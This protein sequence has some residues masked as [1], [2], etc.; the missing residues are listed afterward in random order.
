MEKWQKMVF[1]GLASLTLA[2]CGTGGQ[3]PADPGGTDT[4]TTGPALP[5]TDTTTETPGMETPT[6][7]TAD[8]MTMD[9]ILELY[10]MEYPDAQIEEVDFDDDDHN[11]WTYEITGVYENREYEVEY[12][13][14]TGDVLNTEEDDADTDEEYLNFDNI[15]DPTEAISI[16]RQQVNDDATL[17]GWHLDMDDGVPEYEVEFEGT[18]DRDVTIHAETGDVIEIDD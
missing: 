5:G 4:G 10:W 16:A 1:T 8:V 11:R 2:A 18:D 15:M 13:A 14:M 6:D 9:E 7:P 17:E 12:D 3:T